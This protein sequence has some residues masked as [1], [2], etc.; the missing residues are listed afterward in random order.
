MKNIFKVYIDADKHPNELP[1]CMNVE[2]GD[3]IYVFNIEGKPL[4]VGDK[5]R[6]YNAIVSKVYSEKHWWKF[7]KA[8]EV[9]GYE[10]EFI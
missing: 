6:N 5:Y 7:W 3:R 10:I 2:K 4:S 9:Y 1:K 8:P